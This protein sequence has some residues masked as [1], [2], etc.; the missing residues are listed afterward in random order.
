VVSAVKNHAAGLRKKHEETLA[1][2]NTLDGAIQ[3]TDN[4]IK[5][6]EY[7]ERGCA[8]TGY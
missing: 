8:L 3:E 1:T 5:L 6:H 7:K 4:F 2:L